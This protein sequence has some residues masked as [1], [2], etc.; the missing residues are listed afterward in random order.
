LPG[1]SGG[2]KPFFQNKFGFFILKISR[3]LKTH[4]ISLPFA[5]LMVLKQTYPI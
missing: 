1:F 2:K 4:R 5:L 3:F